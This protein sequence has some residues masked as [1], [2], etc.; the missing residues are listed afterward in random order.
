M[1]SVLNLKNISAIESFSS[2]FSRLGD[3]YILSHIEEGGKNKTGRKNA[4]VPS[5]NLDLALKKPYRLDG[6]LIITMQKGKLRLMVNS[7]AYTVKTSHIFVVSPG[8]LISFDRVDTPVSFSTLFISSTFLHSIN[9]D[10]NAIDLRSLMRRPKPIMRL[11]T[12]EDA[13]IHKYFELLDTNASYA[14]TSVLS[15][16]VARMLISSI[17][18]EILRFAT[19]KAAD[20]IATVSDDVSSEFPGRTQSYIYKYMQ[21]LH[22][23]YAKE[24]SLSFYARQLC[25]TP[26]YLTMVA[27]EATGLTASELLNRVVILEAKNLLCFSGRNIQQVAYDLNFPSQSAFG[28]YFKRLTGQS[29][30][31]FL[32]TI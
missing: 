16:R 2:R 11:T 14:P 19:M 7:E 10:L 31:E 25:I 8:T 32:K 15:T 3:L 6:L 24:R 1:E 23:H 30:S 5:E 12:H 29:P 9:I 20:E 4:S 21:L 13:V 27:K 17:A 18:Y 22:I 26:K 28:K